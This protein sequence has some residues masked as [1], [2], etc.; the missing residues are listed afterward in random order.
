MAGLLLRRVKD[1]ADRT[2]TSHFEGVFHA[3]VHQKALYFEVVTFL[4]VRRLSEA[5]R[6]RTEFGTLYAGRH[7]LI[8]SGVDTHLSVY[9]ILGK[10]LCCFSRTRLSGVDTRSCLPHN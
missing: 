10:V 7:C 9:K 6:K 3:Q 4:C 5:A 2:R 1:Y 8:D